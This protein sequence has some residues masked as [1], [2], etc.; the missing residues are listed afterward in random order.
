MNVDTT[1][2]TAGQIMSHC[3]GC[4]FFQD[5]E[6]AGFLHGQCRRR[7]PTQGDSGRAQWPIVHI[8]N[9]CGDYTSAA[10]TEPKK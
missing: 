4:D 1:N 3:I 6:N 8:D 9:W 2:M 10:T 5:D 7:A